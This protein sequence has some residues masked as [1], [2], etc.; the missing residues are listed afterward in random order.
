MNPNILRARLLIQQDRFELAEEQLHLALAQEPSAEAHALLAHCLCHRE[1]F[2]EATQEA[3]LAIVQDPTDSFGHYTLACVMRQRNRLSEARQSIQEAIRLQP[4][5]AESFSVLAG[6]ECLASQW[7]DCLKAAEQGLALNADH[8]GCLNFRAM[9]LT[10]LGRREQA[11]QSIHE[12]MRRNPDNAATHANEGWRLLHARQPDLA[13]QHFQESLRLD[14]GSEW[15][16]NGIVEA[17][18]ARHFIYRWL[19]SFFLW[20]NGFTPRIQLVLMLGLVFGQRILVAVM[21]SIPVLE[22]FSPVIIVGYLLFVWMCWSA[23]ALFDLVLMTSRFGRLALTGEKKTLA[24]LVGICILTSVLVL[25]ICAM[26]SGAL[27]QSGRY[28]AAMLFLGMTI[29]V[30]TTFHSKGHRRKFAIVWTIGLLALIV[31]ANIHALRQPARLAKAIP[32]SMNA[33]QKAKARLKQPDEARWFELEVEDLLVDPGDASE[34]NAFVNGY[35]ARV[36]AIFEE[37]ST[38]FVYSI[39]GIALSTWLGA[40]LAM[41]PVRR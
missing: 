6:I 2:D 30:V 38:L 21:D 12:A 40:A 14:P 41:I 33:E 7:T 26:Q 10:K 37:S 15:A 13:M 34:K 19:L 11:G 27:V 22:P 25:T 24:A 17:M 9:A 5:D 23:S 31:T 8:I 20:M 18:K 35:K 32:E 1:K 39:W 29:P 28:A 3:Q 4:W 36:R 16:R